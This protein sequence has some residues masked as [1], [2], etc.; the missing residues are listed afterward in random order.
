MAKVKEIL[1]VRLVVKLELDGIR[2]ERSPFSIRIEEQGLVI[3]QSKVIFSRGGV[4]DFVNVAVLTRIPRSNEIHGR[5]TS[6]AFGAVARA[7]TYYRLKFW[8]RSMG[9]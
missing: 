6:G 2:T 5:R 4:L 3:V 9:A 8:L 1:C 7:L